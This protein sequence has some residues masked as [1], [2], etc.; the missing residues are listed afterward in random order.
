MSGNRLILSVVCAALLVLSGGAKKKYSEVGGTVF[1]EPGLALAGAKV[2]IFLE[3]TVKT[4]KLGEQETNDRGEFVFRVP[5]IASTY[6]VKASLK[7]YGDQQKEATVN[8]A[9]EHVDVNLVLAPV[10]K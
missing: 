10:K 8:S 4:K 5:G 7:G 2:V 9:D 3:G 1:R 6:L